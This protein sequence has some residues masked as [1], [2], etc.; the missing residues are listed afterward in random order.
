MNAGDL[1]RLIT[2]E[3][4][5]YSQNNFGASV[6]SWTLEGEQWAKKHEG[7]GREFFT[8]AKV[9]AELSAVFEMRYRPDLKPTWRIVLDGVNFDIL[10]ISEIG[11]R[12]GLLVSVKANIDG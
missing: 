12:V 4:P 8:A 7:V 9:H 3:S 1:D 6:E 10:G 11:R 2:L 5:S